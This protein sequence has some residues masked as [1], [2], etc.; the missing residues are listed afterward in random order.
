[1]DT[2]RITS[3]YTDANDICAVQP[4]YRPTVTR[5]CACCDQAITVSTVSD[6]AWGIL[7]CRTCKEA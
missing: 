7:V 4:I 1:M 3:I 5:F 2:D 6:D